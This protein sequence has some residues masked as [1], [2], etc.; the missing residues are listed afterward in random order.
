M[1]KVCDKCHGDIIRGCCPCG[2][3]SK[4]GEMSNIHQNIGRCLVEFSKTNRD[5]SSYDHHLGVSCVF[6]KG[7]YDMCMKAVKFIED[8]HKE[9]K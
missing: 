4:I 5:I 9:Y 8:L 1:E 3:W 6:F 2:E 7:D